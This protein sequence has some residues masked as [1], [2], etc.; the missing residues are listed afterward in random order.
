MT[1]EKFTIRL[2]HFLDILIE[3]CY[4]AGI[5]SLYHSVTDKEN[6]MN[7]LLFSTADQIWVYSSYYLRFCYAEIENYVYY[8]SMPDLH[9][10]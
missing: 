10:K 9:E 5:P 2:K 1:D 7:L 4:F 8:P 3:N 6:D